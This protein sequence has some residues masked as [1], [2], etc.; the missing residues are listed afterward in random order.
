MICIIRLFSDQEPSDDDEPE[1]PSH[2]ES[3]VGGLTDPPSRL[4]PSSE[5]CYRL[6]LI[7]LRVELYSEAFNVHVS[8]KLRSE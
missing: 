8:Q 6:S 7:E 5:V 3:S 1:D 4:S 2:P